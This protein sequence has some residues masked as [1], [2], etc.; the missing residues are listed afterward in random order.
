[1]Y[2]RQLTNRVYVSSDQMQLS[3]TAN[4]KILAEEGTE[5]SLREHGSGDYQSQED[6][7][8]LTTNK[9]IRLERSVKA[10]YHP[11]T[12]SLPRNGLQNVSCLWH[13]VV[14]ARNGI[15]NTSF[16]ESYRYSANLESESLFDL[17]EN[18]S[19]MQIT[20][21]FQG[22][23]HLGTLKRPAPGREEDIFSVE[24]YAGYFQ[25]EGSVHDLGQGLMIDRSASGQGYVAK[26][27]QA[28]GRQRSYESGSGAYRSEERSDTF[29]GFMAKDLDA[30]YDNISHIVTPR[31][32]LNIS[33]KWSEGMRLHSPSSLIAEEYSSATRLK[34]KA[35]AA[36]PR[37]MVSEAN[38]SGTAKLRTVVGTNG[39]PAVDR[40][41]M[42]MGDYEVSRRI[43]ISGIA[44]YDRPHIYLRKDGL[45]VGD[46]AVYTITITNDGNVAIGPLFLQ[47]LFPPGARFLN[48]TLR[49]NQ[50]GQNGSNWT[51]LHL[52]IGD[53][54][55]I[56]INL[57]VEKCQ[58][59][60]IN[61]ARV[62][63][64]CSTG[65]VI[66]QNL[67]VIDRAWL[68]VYPYTTWGGG[69]MAGMPCLLYTSPSPRD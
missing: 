61:R 59:D 26:D 22:L 42:L 64:N 45:R 11:T 63:G 41:E 60:I 5:L 49:P 19:L 58:G 46:V 24:D 17:D 47:D 10:S 25:L 4:V 68:D 31:T 13:E 56:G 48:A 8:F 15:T 57:D 18:G 53:T 66:A 7:R 67:S 23:A 33:Q 12:I 32:F 40:D 34:M 65:Q 20:S 3:A 43:M 69:G 28:S 62:V 36:S 16:T 55:R 30:S 50:I 9:S 27:T 35:T 6:L 2:K 14:R 1:M 38:F 29:S 52:S 51:L 21:D 39:T 54:L 44:K 37:E